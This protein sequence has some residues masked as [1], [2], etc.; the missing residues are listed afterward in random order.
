VNHDAAMHAAEARLREQWPERKEAST[1]AV[2]AIAYAS[3]HHAPWLWDGVQVALHI[4][5]VT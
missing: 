1:E 2:A 5:Q 3:S 4:Q